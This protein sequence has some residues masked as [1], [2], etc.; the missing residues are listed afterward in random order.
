MNNSF[1]KV[2]VT[3]LTL[4]MVMGGSTAAFASNDKGKG[5][6]KDK[7][8]GRDLK[9]VIETK[10]ND[11]DKNNNGI[12]INNMN[13]KNLNIKLSFDDV[14]GADVEWA[15]RYIASLASKR[16][17][18]GYEDGTF[19]P[20]K[21]ITRIEAITAAVRLMGLRDQ[22]ESAEAKAANLNFKDADKLKSSYSWATGYVSVALQNDLFE[23]SDDMIN[24]GKEA[25]RL[26]ATTLLIKALK[27]QDEAKT[28]M[29]TKLT[30]KDANKIPAGSVGYIALAIDKKLI[31]GYEDNTFRPNNPVTRAEL[32]ALLDRTGSQLPDNASVSGT[33]N[34]AVSNN[35]L[36]LTVQGQPYSVELDSGAFIFR[37]GAKVAA[38]ELRAGDEVIVRTYG[39][40]AIFVE[41][42]KLGNGSGNQLPDNTNFTA[43]VS[44]TVSNNILT[45]IKDG[46]SY[47]AELASNV[48]I[49]RNGQSVA[50]SELRVGDEILVRTS[51]GKVVFVAVTTLANDQ[52]TNFTV[53]GTYNSYTTNSSDQVNSISINKILSDGSVQ[54]NVYYNTTSNVTF[55]YATSNGTIQG[56]RSQLTPNRSVELRGTNNVVH[57]IV[58][59]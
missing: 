13:V 5:N 58:I 49:I 23:E 11:K 50:A 51:G 16:V 30:F 36:T 17:F 38:S 39:G 37:N 31:D 59:K 10:Y 47:S 22:A 34:T 41:V 45:V 43:S 14:K 48:S 24:P 53:N 21:T 7:D 19:Q 46:Q 56:D 18:E 6:D 1:K 9:N 44:F 8:R 15:A 52:Q 28:K 25:D 32:A 40:K 35:L 33:V 2:V 4:A 27:L 55:L 20:R 29:N 3:G 57:T 26:W 54:N 12:Y 42:K